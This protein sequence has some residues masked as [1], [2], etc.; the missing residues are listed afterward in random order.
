MVP[1][2]CGVQC[3]LLPRDLQ[4]QA[5]HVRVIVPFNC[6][7]VFQTALLLTVMQSS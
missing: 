1:V 7:S 5:D 2:L 6:G 3:S 4:P